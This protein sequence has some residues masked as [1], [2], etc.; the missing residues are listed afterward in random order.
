MSEPKPNQVANEPEVEKPDPPAEP[1]SVTPIAKPS[2]D[3]LA[4]FK[5][6]RPANA[7]GVETLI[8]ALP[9]H[10]ISHAK[11]FVR[12][13][14]NETDYWSNELCF[15]QVPIV[16]QRKDTLHLIDEDLARAFLPSGKILRFRLALATKPYD[17]FF[18]AHIPTTSVD[19]P[20]NISNLRGCELAK[21]TW[22][23]LTSRKAEGAEQYKIDHA[24]DA[25]AFP[26]PKWP[27]QSL[28][29][30]MVIAFSPDRMIEGQDHPALLR[31]I[32]AKQPRA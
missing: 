14:S 18:L 20:W 15:V 8:E 19:N 27:T 7:G 12:L 30:L 32:G 24:R 2:D 22:V 5:S 31:L 16:G 11:D 3:P 4:K 6:K 21:T 13:N 25:D 23:Q 17:V 10:P 9:H 26:E 29:S 1:A 28:S